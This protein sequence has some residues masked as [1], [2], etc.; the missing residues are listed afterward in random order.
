MSPGRTPDCERPGETYPPAP[1]RPLTRLGAMLVAAPSVL[2]GR[3]MIALGLRR[4]HEGWRRTVGILL[5]SQSTRFALSTFGLRVPA[6][7][8]GRD[9]STASLQE[10]TANAL[11]LFLAGEPDAHFRLE[12][13]VP[14]TVRQQVPFVDLVV[15]A[16][17]EEGA[18]QSVTP[19]LAATGGMAPGLETR[20][21]VH[22]TVVAAYNRTRQLPEVARTRRLLAEVRAA[23]ESR[24]G[25]LRYAERVLAA[26]CLSFEDVGRA[27]TNRRFCPPAFARRRTLGFGYLSWVARPNSENGSVDLWV[28]AHHVGL[29]GVPLQDLL[30]RLEDAWGLG[31]SV[32]FPPATNGTAFHGPERC[33][34]S[35]ERPVDQLLTFVDFSSVVALRRK[36]NERYASEIGGEATFGA[37]VAWLLSQE[38]ELTGVRIAS[39]VDVPASLGYE[40]DVDVVSLRPADYMSGIDPWSG[41]VEYAREFNR[42]IA[43]ARNRT[44]PVRVGMQAAG[45]IPPWAHATLVRADPASLDATFGTLCVTIIRDARVFVAPMTD[46]GLGHG[47]FAIG[48][49]HLPTASG[50]RVTAV[51][52]KGDAG[53]VGSY[54]AILQRVIDRA[55][56]LSNA[57]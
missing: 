29:D 5:R 33:H 31:E 1:P 23:L 40:R 26:S 10:R 49:A 36:L 55:A 43:A 30:N 19:Y 17:D 48:S 16:F 44:S 12:W 57:M 53:R 4:A 39:T 37:L 2:L 6:A 7:V 47:F 42:V 9:V 20:T 3:S 54:P 21:H 41:F 22:T 45:L 56:A 25:A 18:L 8:A 51:T 24:P 38:P 13:R 27:D 34:A 28:S 46:L 50:A 52:V 15:Q 35:G 11:L 14:V 32:L